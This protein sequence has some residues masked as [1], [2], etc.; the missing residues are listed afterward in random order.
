MSISGSS[1]SALVAFNN[2]LINNT[3]FYDNK[4]NHVECPIKWYLGSLFVHRTASSSSWPSS[5]HQ[6][7]DGSISTRTIDEQTYLLRVTCSGDNHWSTFM[8]PANSNSLW[9]DWWD[10][11]HDFAA[12]DHSNNVTKPE[13][14]QKVFSSTMDSKAPSE[15]EAKRVVVGHF[16]K[17]SKA[18]NICLGL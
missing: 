1:L 10:E 17:S 16:T 4:S 9:S 8:R 11:M 2:S 3:C 14:S 12:A 6:S 15:I 13:L 7:F 5:K 18:Y